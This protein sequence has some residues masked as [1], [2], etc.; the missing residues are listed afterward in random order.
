MGGRVVKVL[1]VF[2]ALGVLVAL[3][4]D[5]APYWV[6]LGIIIGGVWLMLRL[7]DTG[8]EGRADRHED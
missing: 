8:G 5:A 1:G 6:H 2:L 4:K 3:T 7:W